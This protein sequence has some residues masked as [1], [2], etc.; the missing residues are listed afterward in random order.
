M[1]QQ[2]T[3]S[4]SDHGSAAEAVV[5]TRSH[6]SSRRVRLAALPSAVPWARR[7]LRHMLREWQLEG[8]SDPVLLLVSE[9]VT[10]AVQ[11]SVSQAGRDEDSWPMIG[12][13]LQ[14]TDTVLQLEVWDTSS[15]LPALQEAD[16][17]GERGRGLVLVDFLAD[18]WGHR[19]AGGG[20]VV[21]C[22]VAIPGE[23]AAAY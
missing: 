18:S 19:T 21:W 12:L 13:T 6:G 11:A 22:T 16:L 3:A 23:L 8:M 7:I 17:T 14:L 9:L 1:S 10:N 20:K 4:V 5:P 15:A 2:V